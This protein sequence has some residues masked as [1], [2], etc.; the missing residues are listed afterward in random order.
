MLIKTDIQGDGQP[1]RVT[2]IHDTFERAANGAKIYANRWRSY[3]PTFDA[4]VQRPDGKWVA[5]GTRSAD[6]VS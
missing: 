5:H 6:R 2:L 1:V 4:P 3:A